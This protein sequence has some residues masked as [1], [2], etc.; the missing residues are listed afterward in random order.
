MNPHEPFRPGLEDVVV[1]ETALSLVDGAGGRLVV[2]GFSIEDL[3]ALRFEEMYPYL[4]GIGVDWYATRRQ[5]R[6]SRA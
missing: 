1:A 4:T 3:A 6:H 2:R 5:L